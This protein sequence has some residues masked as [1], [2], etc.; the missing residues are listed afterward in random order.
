MDTKTR[1]GELLVQE[2]IITEAQLAEALDKR[3]T[4]KS[5]IGSILVKLGYIT[6]SVLYAYLAKQANVAF[7]DLKQFPI[8]PE[9]V[10]HLSETT[11]RRLQAIVL[12]KQNDGL[13]VGMTE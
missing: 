11:A 12:E 4:E 13:L 3:G 7:I 5:K 6:E 2:K 10:F 9:L 8:N 1:L